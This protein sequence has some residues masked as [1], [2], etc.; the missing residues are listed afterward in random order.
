[1]PYGLDRI[2]DALA[3]ADRF[4]AIGTS[5]AVYP[6][7][8]YAEMARVFGVATCEINLAP[9]DNADAFEDR[10]YGPATVAVP[11]YVAELLGATGGRG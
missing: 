4:V 6:A 7:A 2:E 3:A 1:M 8:G 5:G 10:R 11:A 9:S